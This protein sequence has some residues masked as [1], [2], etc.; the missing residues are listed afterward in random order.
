MNIKQTLG[1]LTRQI[2]GT[3]YYKKIY[4]PIY[5]AAVP[6]SSEYPEVYNK[7]GQKMEF[8]FI[9][10]R[11]S[12]HLPYIGKSNYFIWDRFNIGLK[13]HFYSHNA[14]LETMGTPDHKYG[15]LLEA[16]II[17]PDDYN[18]FDKY[19]GLEKDFDK[20]FT[21]SQRLL[22]NLPNAVYIPFLSTI[23]DGNNP[24]EELINGEAYKNKTKNISMLASA[25]S[26]SDLHIFRK[27]VANKCKQEGLA[28]TYGNFD[29]GPRINHMADILIPYRYNIAIENY[30]DDL[31]F[32]EKIC[33]CFAS[34][35]VPIYCG[36]S[37]IKDYFN[38]DGIITISPK[39]LDSIGKILAQCSPQDYEQRLPAIKDNFNRVLKYKNIDDYLYK[40]IRNIPL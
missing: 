34:M 22:E 36:T 18:I 20:I 12:A 37:K 25:K 2:K 30:I 8:F 24:Q 11:H 27:A 4:S 5:N 33:N 26:F 3:N 19:K 40:T 15:M 16:E 10:D 14:M 29:G 6:I 9:R 31:Y 39:D 38:Q 32:T 23:S 13:N 35:T 21:F 7:N 17:T 1:H 28:D